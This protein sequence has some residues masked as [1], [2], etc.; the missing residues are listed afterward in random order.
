MTSTTLMFENWLRYFESNSDFVSLK[1]Q[2]VPIG[3]R[4]PLHWHFINCDCVS[5]SKKPE[6]FPVNGLCHTLQSSICEGSSQCQ[7]LKVLQVLRFQHIVRDFI[8]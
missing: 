6:M 1:C 8:S 3:I 5:A 2:Q 7:G 4:S